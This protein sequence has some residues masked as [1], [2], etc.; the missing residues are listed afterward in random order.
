[1]RKCVQNTTVRLK[2]FSEDVK[3][4]IFVPKAFGES[5]QNFFANLFP[6]VPVA[7][8]RHGWREEVL[9]RFTFVSFIHYA[10]VAQRP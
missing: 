1:M 4:L 2:L 8:L 3:V 7:D 9:G 5:C 6:H 10:S